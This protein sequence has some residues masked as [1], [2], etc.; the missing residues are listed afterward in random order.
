[1][2]HRHLR[3]SISNIVH[4][5]IGR[6]RIE[7]QNRIFIYVFSGFDMGNHFCEFTFD[8]QSA[9]EWPFYKVH[10]TKYP[11]GKQQRNF[12]RSYAN[13]ILSNQ[14]QSS[15]DEIAIDR[16]ELVEQ[17]MKEANYFALASHFFWTL[18]AINMA[19]STTI[20]SGYMVNQSR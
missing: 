8:Y 17:L 3:W 19:I 5:I 13:A 16:D 12:L 18:W 14:D 1:M 15:A 6:V 10:F 4:T 2:N 20:P 11:N 7:F 9:T